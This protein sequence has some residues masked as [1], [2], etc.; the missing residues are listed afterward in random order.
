MVVEAYG[1]FLSHSRLLLF[2]VFPDTCEVA[3]QSFFIAL[4]DDVDEVLALL[5]HRSDMPIVSER[6]YIRNRKH[7]GYRSYHVII[8]YPVDTIDGRKEILAEIQI[9]TL[10]M[11]GHH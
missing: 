3:V 5:R 11:N 6:D 8:S 4:V 1:W 10:A 7:S 2:D 9:R